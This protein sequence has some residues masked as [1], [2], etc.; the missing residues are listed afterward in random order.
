METEDAKTVR[1]IPRTLSGF[2]FI[3]IGIA[4]AAAI[5]ER[6]L[7]SAVDMKSENG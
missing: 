1:E 3:S 5:F 6:T 7:Q 4:T 2:T